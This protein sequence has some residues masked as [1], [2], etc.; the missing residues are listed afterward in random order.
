M[1]CVDLD[2]SIFKKQTPV[3]S[4]EVGIWIGMIL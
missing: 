4:G 3:T 1:Q 2:Q